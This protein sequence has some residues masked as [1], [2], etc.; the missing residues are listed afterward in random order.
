MRMNAGREPRGGPA[1]LIVSLLAVV[2]LLSATPARAVTREGTA[3]A[4]RLQ[5]STGSDV[6]FGFEGDDVLR[7][8]AGDDRLVGGRADDL[9]KGGPGRDTYVCG[10][11][12]DVVVSDYPRRPDEHVGA[13][14]EAVIF[15]V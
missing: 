12:F 8:K 7:G 13:G 4:D 15:E 5:G 10:T 2:L 6:I 1:A 3:E 11:G 14:C 9:L